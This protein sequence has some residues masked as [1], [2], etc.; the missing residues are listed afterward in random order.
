[1]AAPGEGKRSQE[2]SIPP[3]TL[4][5]QRL[6]AAWSTRDSGISV[7]VTGAQVRAAEPASVADAPFATGAFDEDAAHGL[8]GPAKK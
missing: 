1:M 6:Q 2:R 8:G 5:L 7:D 4:D 3:A